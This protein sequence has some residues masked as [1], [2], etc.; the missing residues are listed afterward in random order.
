MS[1]YRISSYC[2][3]VGWHF[4]FSFFFIFRWPDSLV[5]AINLTAT[6]GDFT[7]NMPKAAAEEEKADERNRCRNCKFSSP[8][9]WVSLQAF[10]T[11]LRL[12]PTAGK[13]TS[14]R[15]LE[16]SSLISQHFSA[17]SYLQDEFM[18]RS[19][20]EKFSPREPTSTTT[21]KHAWSGDKYFSAVRL[22]SS[23]RA[24]HFQIVGIFC[25][26]KMCFWRPLVAKGKGSK[27]KRIVQHFIE[28]QKRKVS[29]SR[30]SGE[31]GVNEIRRFN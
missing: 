16:I 21:T 11:Q 18:I 26:G 5:K 19:R 4:L 25:R 9:S 30:S 23:R 31:W 1:V 12:R 13:F 22:T 29:R 27:N 10:F 24:F 2:A 28:S 20:K 15:T 6:G 14:S 3:V 7:F 17:P 8:F